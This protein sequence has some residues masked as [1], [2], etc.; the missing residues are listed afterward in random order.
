LTVG[1]RPARGRARHIG[2]ALVVVWFAV[3]G[4]AH[5]LA[6]D[7]ELRIVPAWVPWPREAVWATGAAELFGAAGLLWQP[8]RRV[9]GL[10]LFLLT[11]AVT[12]ANV[13]M[14]LATGGTGGTGGTG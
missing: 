10:A 14:L 13:Q 6:T 7:A 12:P 11:V 2:L 5:F 3:G 4:L 8:T 9:A 1:R